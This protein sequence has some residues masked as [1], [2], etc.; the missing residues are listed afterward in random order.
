MFTAEQAAAG[1]F[2]LEK[3]HVF[4][5][6][7]VFLY[8]CDFLSIFVNVWSICVSIRY[9]VRTYILYVYIIILVRIPAFHA[10]SKVEHS[11]AE[12]NHVVSEQPF[13]NVL[14]DR[15]L[16]AQQSTSK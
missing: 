9:Y 2:F 10:Q 3:R 11:K 5:Q 13:P 16:R 8:I 4:F 12:H 7:G 1:A 14:F 6:K 15:G